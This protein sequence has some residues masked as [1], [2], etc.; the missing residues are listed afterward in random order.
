MSWSTHLYGLTL[1]VSPTPGIHGSLLHHLPQALLEDVDVPTAVG[2]DGVGGADSDIL[3]CD[4]A[5]LLCWGN[6]DG[7]SMVQ[8]KVGGANAK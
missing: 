7:W 1:P 6:G 8:P 4:R 5:P 2:E 3:R